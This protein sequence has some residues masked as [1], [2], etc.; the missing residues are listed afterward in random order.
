MINS[1]FYKKMAIN[2]DIFPQYINLTDTSFVR[3]CEDASRSTFAVNYS[4]PSN[5]TLRGMLIAWCRVHKIEVANSVIIYI[6]TRFVSCNNGRICKKRVRE[7]VIPACS[8]F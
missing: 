4:V 7:D 6:R 8:V 1:D 2:M 3:R 5:C